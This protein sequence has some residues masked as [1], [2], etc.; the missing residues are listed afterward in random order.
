[1]NTF[2]KYFANDMKIIEKALR[3]ID[4]AEMDK[5]VDACEATIKAGHKIISSGLG[6]NVPVWNNAFP[7][8]RR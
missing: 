6:K 4:V 5:L 7:G 3:S 2:D 1:M 8:I